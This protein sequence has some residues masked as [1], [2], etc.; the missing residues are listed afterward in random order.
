MFPN[1]EP[2]SIHYLGSIDCSSFT[3]EEGLQFCKNQGSPWWHLH[4]C[5]C[6]VVLNWPSTILASAFSRTVHLSSR[7]WNRQIWGEMYF[8]TS[9]KH[10]LLNKA[11]ILGKEMGGGIFGLQWKNAWP[12]QVKI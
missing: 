11:F 9:H 10:V 6:A 3:S 12:L 1:T 2:M 4:S 7:A 8:P 5:M